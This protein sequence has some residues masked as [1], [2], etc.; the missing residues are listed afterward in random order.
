MP[1]SYWKIPLFDLDYD[2]EEI[3]A[4]T[5]VLK[6][7]WLSMGPQVEAFELEFAKAMGVRHAIAVSNASSALYLSLLAVGAR[8]GAE[9]IQP[10]M[11]F[12]AAANMT[13]AVRAIPVFADI[14]SLEKPTISPEEIR[15]KI[16]PNTKAV[17]V[18]HYGGYPCR[19]AEI[20]EI[21]KEQRIALIEDACH[22]IGARYLDS[23]K[24]V[25]HGSYVGGCSDI[26]C[27]SFY[28]NKNLAVGEGGMIVTDRDDLVEPLRRMR[29]HGMTQ[30]VWD[31]HAGA[32]YYDIVSEGFNFRF[33]EVR[34]A[35]GR[36]QLRKLAEKNKKRGELTRRYREGLSHQ[37]RFTV[38]YQN[39]SG[40]SSYHLMSLVA[41]SIEDR[42]RLVRHLKEAGVQTTLHY[43]CLSDLTSFKDHDSNLT[44]VSR[45][46][47]RGV[48]VV[49]L[50]PAMTFEQVDWICD[51]ICS[52]P[53]STL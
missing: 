42:M 27:F 41:A 23:E 16:T 18:M 1:S 46:F 30:F 17:I 11:N 44:P 49:P 5:V 33:D 36:I 7:K 43:P 20:V 53:R 39:Y 4:A 15:R 13:R 8:D 28:S 21:C 3:Q 31:R 48:V 6:S 12:V 14:L 38:V 50:F 24:K 47:G 22:A 10:A 2:D 9:V 26:G 40:D 32:D 25:P 34:A 35:M 52:T 37:D 29:C 51:L 45:D 19:M